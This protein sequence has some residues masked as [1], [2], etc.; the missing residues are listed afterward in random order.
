MKIIKITCVHIFIKNISITHIDKPF[1][2]RWICNQLL[3]Q[4]L[5]TEVGDLNKHRWLNW[6]ERSLRKR[7]VS[8]SNPTASDPSRINSY[9]LGN[10]SNCHGSSEITI[11]NGIYV[12]QL[13]GTLKNPHWA[14]VKICSSS[15]VMVT[16]PY[17]WQTLEWDEKPQTNKQKVISWWLVNV[18]NYFSLWKTI[19]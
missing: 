10:R 3:I 14:L 19:E 16:S 12:L 15:P 6:L 17:E 5:T 1:P 2:F 13:C 8:C 18:S 11:I 4:F 9:T 7:K